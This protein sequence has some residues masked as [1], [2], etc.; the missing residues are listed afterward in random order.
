MVVFETPQPT[1]VGP[2]VTVAFEA[3]MVTPRL[4]GP[5]QVR[6]RPQLGLP[7]VSTRNESSAKCARVRWPCAIAV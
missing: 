5:S 2:N 6:Y 1:P 7:S 3:V 4:A